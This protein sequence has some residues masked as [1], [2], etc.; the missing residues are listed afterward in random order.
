MSNRMNM[1]HRMFLDRDLLIND[2]KKN[3]GEREG[4]LI[5]VGIFFSLMY[6]RNYY[7]P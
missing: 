5:I 7:L 6:L 3:K 4:T 2:D 1:K